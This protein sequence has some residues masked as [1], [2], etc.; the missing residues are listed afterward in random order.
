[1]SKDKSYI[2]EKLG[3]TLNFLPE[4]INFCCS[5]AEGPNI[6]YN[7]NEE[8][9]IKKII[10]AEKQY[11]KEL[12]HGQIPSK[13]SGC[14]DFKEKHYK[15]IFDYYFS[16]PTNFLV[17]QIIVNH[18]KQCDCNCVYCAQKILYGQ[19]TSQNY[20][21][22]P[23]IRE[24]YKNNMIDRNDLK[25]EFQGGNISVLD[26]F[27]ALM[28]LFWINGCK[29]FIILTNGIKYLPILEDAMYH[30]IIELN[31]SLDAGTKD[32]YSKIKQVDAFEQVINNIKEFSIKTNALINLKYIIIKGMNDNTWELAKFLEIV[33]ELRC[34]NSICLDIDYRDIV[35]DKSK[36]FEVPKQY[37]DMVKLAEN[38]GREN[39]VTCI[40]APFA[41]Q[42][43]E[44]N[45][46]KVY[47]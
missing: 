26:E 35:L 5:Y 9:N 34:A 33:K 19:E 36:N 28:R 45:K 41:K 4:K 12:K 22:L 20:E 40:V 1:M 44:K 38:F 24:L 43:M 47:G 29:R 15:N 23:I 42:Y 16:K 39:R 10:E 8:F 30:S 6:E 31:I 13:C 3:Q 7:K 32:T 18:F 27:E 14:I 2:C 37:Y 17:N 25:V 11:I 46:E 21:L